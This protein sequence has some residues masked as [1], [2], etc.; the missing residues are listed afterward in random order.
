MAGRLL[1]DH[2][3]QPQHVVGA[4]IDGRA[5]CTA[6]I[7]REGAETVATIERIHELLEGDRLRWFT[8]AEA[9]ASGRVDCEECGRSLDGVG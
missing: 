5:V 9:L 4:V 3:F 6:H 7:A 1:G 2:R 8:R